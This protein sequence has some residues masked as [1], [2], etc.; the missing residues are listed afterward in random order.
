MT[1]G[2]TYLDVRS[3]PEFAQGHPAG[4]LNVPLMH[5]EAGR[6]LA[7]GDFQKVILANFSLDTKLVVGCKSGGRSMR[8]VGILGGL[9]YEN[10]VDVRGGFS[11]ETDSMGRSTAPGWTETGLPVATKPEPGRSYADLEKKS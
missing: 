9:G 8:A 10:L 4:A 11:G 7:N 1:A 6:M 3:V 2:W 5:A